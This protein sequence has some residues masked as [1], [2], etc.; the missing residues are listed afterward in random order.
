MLYWSEPDYLDQLKSTAPGLSLQVKK[1]LKLAEQ[2]WLMTKVP[3]LLSPSFPP[4]MHKQQV[5]LKLSLFL[6][7]SQCHVINEYNSLPFHSK[8]TISSL[9]VQNAVTN[10]FCDTPSE[11]TLPIK[12]YWMGSSTCSA[13]CGNVSVFTCENGTLHVYC[14]VT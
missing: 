14:N 3:L 11:L 8:Q 7:L 9:G 12:W 10:K 4:P 13:D 6:S 1:V 5:Q 2:K